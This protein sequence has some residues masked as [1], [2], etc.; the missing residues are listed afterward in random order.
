[1]N[2]KPFVTKEHI[3]AIMAALSYEFCII[4][5]TTT[6][7]CAAVHPNGF[8]LAT[9][10]SAC[11]C[12][13]NFNEETGRYWAKE[14]AMKKAEK[15]LWKLEGYLLKHQLTD[16]TFSHY[17]E[18]V[19]ATDCVSNYMK[20]PVVISAIQLTSE[21]FSD[22]ESFIGITELNRHYVNEHDFLSKSNPTGLFIKTLE[23]SML[24]NIG[25]YVIK[26]VQGE[27]YPCKPDIFT[28]TYTPVSA[29]E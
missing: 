11:V 19:N 26:G 18:A 13:E 8:K 10:E 12:P 27:F 5:N 4:P 15:E 28:A 3:A 21:N 14:D 24:A 25:D 16:P 29:N 23:G 6:T 20:K 1:M 2:S 9:G 17:I 22:V 7:I